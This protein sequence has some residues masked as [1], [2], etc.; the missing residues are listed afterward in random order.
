MKN[1]KLLTIII[2]T[3][4]SESI[5]KTCLEN[6]DFDKYEVFVVDNN[7]SDNT[8]K[9]IEDQFP[10]VNLIKLEQNIGYG[11]ANNIALKKTKTPYAL[12]LNPDA[13]ISDD[14]IKKSNASFYD[15]FTRLTHN[16][17]DKNSIYL[18]LYY[19]HDTAEIH[20]ELIDGLFRVAPP[21]SAPLRR[22]W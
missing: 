12:I 8:V 16:L 6:I 19:S 21:M 13:I 18:S 20:P 22:H 1:Q 4:Q 7:S 14:D 15:F 2:T 5:I 3:F 9:I 10:K 11:R 17:N